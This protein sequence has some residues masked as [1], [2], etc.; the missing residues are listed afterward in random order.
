MLSAPMPICQK[1]RGRP[2]LLDGMSPSHLVS[3]LWILPSFRHEHEHVTMSPGDVNVQYVRHLLAAL[4]FP[5]F[6]PS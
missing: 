6:L 2:A 5:S 4:G 1:N 3:H